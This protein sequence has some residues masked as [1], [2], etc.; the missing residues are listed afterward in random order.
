MTDMFNIMPRYC[1]VKLHIPVS[2]CTV[3]MKM[4]LQLHFSNTFI[5][6][7]RY[8]CFCPSFNIMWILKASKLKELQVILVQ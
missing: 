3:L 8:I 7:C 4:Y 5:Y 1:T 2:V 6:T